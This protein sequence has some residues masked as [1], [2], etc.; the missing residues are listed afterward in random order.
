MFEVRRNKFYT[1]CGIMKL[2]GSPYTDIQK[3][4]TG[5][6]RKVYIFPL[7][8]YYKTLIMFY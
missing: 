1:Y 4:I 3:D 6:N 2:I 7:K 5:N 8:K